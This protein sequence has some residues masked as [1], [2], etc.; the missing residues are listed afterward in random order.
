MDNNLSRW[1]RKRIY[2]LL[3]MVFIINTAATTNKDTRGI[4]TLSVVKNVEV[5]GENI[6]LA[7]M[8]SIDGDDNAL[9]AKLEAIFMGEAP[10]PGKTRRF[11]CKDIEV[12]LK[13]NDIDLSRIKIS[14]AQDVEVIRGFTKV[15]EE[16]IENIVTKE[17][18]YVLNMDSNEIFIKEIK[19]ANGIILPKG[20]Y[21]YTVAPSKNAD[22]TSKFPVS[23]IFDVN[24]QFTKKVY[25][26]V[27]IER[28]VDVVVTK[29]IIPKNQIIDESDLE[30]KKMN[31]GD[32][33][34]NYISD[35]LD[36]VG[37]KLKRNAEK[38]FVLRSD[39]IDIP[40]AIQRNDVV[41][42]V[43]E[44]NYFKIVTLGEAK[45]KGYKGDRIKVVN[46]ESNNEVYAWV[47]DSKSV[48]VGF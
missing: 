46:L 5:A 45:E 9:I 36:A 19:A 11:T 1:R 23:V 38:G 43:A 39:F 40:P 33:P 32:L 10:L 2:L 25:V 26:T 24:G 20:H 42:M 48:K 6:I 7:D 17:L 41:L 37:N 3:I 21:T 13:K 27:Q 35:T 31:S 4:V 8:V 15:T 14:G 34:A 12:K 29:R 18:P 28:Y 44:S 16:Q 30:V 22:L 47:I